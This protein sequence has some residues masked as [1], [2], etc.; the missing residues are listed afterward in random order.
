MTSELFIM[1]ALGPSWVGPVLQSLFILVCVLMVLVVLIQK[2][3]GGGLAGAFGGSSAGSGQTAFG[4]K[5]GDALTV[6]T[7]SVFVIFV[8][9]AILL[10]LALK[11]P[12]PEKAAATDAAVSAPAS[13]DAPAATTDPA[14]TT[15]ASG[16]DTILP[17]QLPE[18]SMSPATNSGGEL[19]A[20]VT[21]PAVPAPTT[22]EP[23]TPAPTA[24][25]PDAPKP[26]PKP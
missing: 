2:P 23:T 14:T 11:A 12:G 20:T 5:T 3:Q 24:P 1:A 26:E 19:P 18:G 16:S 22:P 4:T 9:I 25:T 17:T 7:V 10:N 21:T 13:T 8:V 15:P 6:F